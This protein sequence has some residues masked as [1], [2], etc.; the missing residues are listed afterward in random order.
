MSINPPVNAID[1]EREFAPVS[2]NDQ[3]DSGWQRAIA[4]L[5]GHA[6][7]WHQLASRA[8]IVLGEA[9]S[10]KTAEL[11]MRAM[12]IRADGRYAFAI[13]LADVN[14]H[15]E[16]VIGREWA[17]FEAWLDGDQEATF[18]LDGLD[19][20]KATGNALDAILDGI[21]AWMGPA[22]SRARL[23]LSA[24]PSEWEPVADMAHMRTA[25]AAWAP[26]RTA[27]VDV[28]LVSLVPL[29]VERARRYA[30]GLGVPDVDAFIDAIRADG[31]Q[32]FMERPRDV[33]WLAA[34]WLAERRL[35][36]LRALIDANVTQKLSDRRSV[37]RAVNLPIDRARSGVQRLA[38]IATLSATP[39]FPIRDSASAAELQQ[40]PVEILSDWRPGDVSDLLLLPIF[41]ESTSTTLRIHTKAVQEYLCAEWL[42]DRLRTGLLTQDRVRALLFRPAGPNTVVPPHLTTVAAWLAIDEPL[43]CDMLIRHAPQHLL[44]EGDPAAIPVTTRE[45]ILRAYATHFGDRDR[46]DIHFDRRG[47]RRFASPELAPTIIELLGEVDA[48][49]VRA[50]LLDIV[51]AGRLSACADA[52]TA[53]AI[54]SDTDAHVRFAAVR[55][56]A[57]A[58]GISH[59]GALLALLATASA[60]E[61]DVVGALIANLFP[62]PLTPA[63]LKDA[64]LAVAPRGRWNRITRLDRALLEEVAERC[65]DPDRMQ[66]IDALQEAVAASADEWLVRPMVEFVANHLERAPADVDR[67]E[68]QRALTQLDT[69]DNRWDSRDPNL[70]R[71]VLAAR[72]SEV[73]RRG[74]LRWFVNRRQ[75]QGDAI[76]AISLQRALIVGASLQPA[77]LRWLEGEVP[78]VAT[79]AATARAWLET[80]R[81]EVIHPRAEREPAFGPQDRQYIRD[82]AADFRAGHQGL[83]QR[84][85][86]PYM[87]GNDWGTIDAARMR[88]DLDTESVGAIRAGLTQVW[89]HLDVPVPRDA[90]ENAT[91]GAVVLG[92]IGLALDF[93]DGLD[94]NSLDEDVARRAARL[95]LWELNH[96][97]PWLPALLAAHRDIVIQ[98]VIDEAIAELRDGAGRE[99]VL[100]KAFSGPTELRRTLGRE[101]ERHVVDGSLPLSTRL[102][103]AIELLLQSRELDR[104]SW[105][106]VVRDGL[107]SADDDPELWTLLWALQFQVD[108]AAATE[109]V[110]RLAGSAAAADRERVVA[111]ADVLWRWSDRTG[112]ELDFDV[113]AV[114]A[115]YI[116]LVHVQDP[117]ASDFSSTRRLRAAM[118]RKLEAAGQ[119]GRDVFAR[120]AA[121]TD[122][123]FPDLR[124]FHLA[125][126]R[127]A[128][129][130]DPSIVPMPRPIAVQWVR[131]C[132]ADPTTEDGL[133]ELTLARLTDIATFLRDHRFSYR[134][135]FAN[136]EGA[137]AVRERYFQLWLAAE[138]HARSAR[139]YNVVREEE[140]REQK[141]PDLRTHVTGLRPTS[142]ELKVAES[143]NLAELRAALA[144]QLVGQYMGEVNSQH[145]ILV[146]CATRHRAT[147]N[148]P[149][150]PKLQLDD[151]VAMLEAEARSLAESQVRDIRRL[152]IVVLDFRGPLSRSNSG[153]NTRGKRPRKKPAKKTDGK[154]PA[155]KTAGRK[156]AKKT[157]G[158]K[159]AKKA[160]R[161][162][163]TTTAGKKQPKKK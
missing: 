67:P 83:L 2:E 75:Q 49:D 80:P 118:V 97:P 129:Y 21:A 44:D 159:P 114:E 13:R 138:L 85:T 143:W 10:G 151:V 59:R 119:P 57:R 14:A 99:R 105:A 133:Y 9:G 69:D 102:E 48:E 128:E 158:K 156:P 160:V 18:F 113:H 122:G 147:W 27:D 17:D 157:A 45:R 34:R 23:V 89:R 88:E 94:A 28:V 93:A 37:G 29:D 38:A 68:V 60:L 120:L 144:T 153:G 149:G 74:L 36:P 26:G 77:D 86:G 11:A 72:E 56:A 108:S 103:P 148:E 43:V 31:L 41:D 98:E 95:A 131:D 101:I 81:V 132:E 8:V 61:L 73:L 15:V 65:P 71:L 111:L 46:T 110:E 161:T 117:N 106:L 54:A 139:R 142:L 20:A 5:R 124:D 107:A 116:A 140:E 4:R 35:G 162:K 109:R 154:K 58:G 1:L 90:T 19:E 3:L 155:K 62:D 123:S 115:L 50:T 78:E 55:A 25:L 79:A 24:R 112:I 96:F 125:A 87:S 33:E 91:P 127:R 64:L 121:R 52:A 70:E 146:V 16:R 42:V 76:T 63:L 39:S 100:H 12:V 51:A 137:K 47:L 22:R 30:H 92:L 53:I 145:G 163:A 134:D 82:H 104:A 136:F 6:W 32:D 7:R 126:A 141:R 135:V 152:A 130:A 84:A 150:G 40:R 66:V